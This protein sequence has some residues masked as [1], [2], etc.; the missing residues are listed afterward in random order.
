MTR[1]LSDIPTHEL[2]ALVEQ[3]MPVEAYE[4]EMKRRQER[5]PDH[6]FNCWGN[7][8]V[9]RAEYTADHTAKSWRDYYKG[10]PL[11][12]RITHRIRV[13]MKERAP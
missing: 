3:G 9:W 8:N 5:T 13:F 4:A 7:G 12:N 6:V 11:E 1:P 10:K 2:P